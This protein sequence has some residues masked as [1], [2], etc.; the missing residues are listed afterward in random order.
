MPRFVFK[1]QEN[2]SPNTPSQALSST[3]WTSVA[4]LLLFLRQSR[5]VVLDAASELVILE[6]LRG[7][8]RGESRV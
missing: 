5:S 7:V 6:R 3:V 4:D 8:M 2:L 1:A